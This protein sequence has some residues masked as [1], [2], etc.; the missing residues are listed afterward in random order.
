MSPAG[1]AW[2]NTFATAAQHL[3][4]GGIAAFHL[5]LLEPMRA[6]GARQSGPAVV[7]QLP[8]ERRAAAALRP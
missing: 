1:A 3:E 6:P 5:P 2:R 4:P 8:R 7:D